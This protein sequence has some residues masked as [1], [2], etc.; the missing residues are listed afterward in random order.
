MENSLTKSEKKVLELMKYCSSQSEDGQ[1][2]LGIKTVMGRCDLSK[3][4]VLRSIKKLIE[5]GY[6]EQLIKGSNFSKTNSVYRFKNETKLPKK[7]DVKKNSTNK[8]DIQKIDDELI[9]LYLPE[10]LQKKTLTTNSISDKRL[11]YFLAFLIRL[12]S[13]KQSQE[14]GYCYVNDDEVSKAIG[15]NLYAVS[16]YAYKLTQLGLVGRCERG[17]LD[18]S[19]A[20]RYWL[21]FKLFPIIDFVQK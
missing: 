13:T 9:S 1:F 2:T 21:S 20:S 8:L 11:K 4:T 5:Y 19:V 12:S 17:S 14:N 3:K 10:E 18:G 15:C 6:I 16:A 7:E